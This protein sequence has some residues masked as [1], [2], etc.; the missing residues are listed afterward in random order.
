MRKRPPINQPVQLNLFRDRP[1]TPHWLD[2]TL[3]ARHR[4][5]PLLV[6]LLRAHTP[7]SWPIAPRR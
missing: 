7:C 5:L 1:L 3:E 4:T 2:L 6:R